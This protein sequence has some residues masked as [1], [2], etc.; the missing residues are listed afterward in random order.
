[1]IPRPII[2]AKKGARIIHT[3]EAIWSMR[4]IYTRTFVPSWFA[5][6][7]GNT[8]GWVRGGKGRFISTAGTR[9]TLFHE[10]LEKARY[11]IRDPRRFRNKLACGAT[12]LIIYHPSF[13]P[14][15][16]RGSIRRFRSLQPRDVI[17]RTRSST[18]KS[19]HCLISTTAEKKWIWF[20][21]CWTNYC[22]EKRESR[23]DLYWTD[24]LLMLNDFLT[25][26][27]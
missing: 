23:F 6:K 8:S 13:R 20:V 21:I 27:H 4:N 1:M 14:V 3:V 10:F 9:R 26:F 24:D 15:S 5:R 12:L 19:V 2:G 16:T 18:C 25:S 7:G 22:W 17:L 11:A